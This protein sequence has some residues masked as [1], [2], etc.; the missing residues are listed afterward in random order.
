M[1]KNIELVMNELS[2]TE[3]ERLIILGKEMYP[4]G[5]GIQEGDTD[6]SFLEAGREMLS[7][8]M[9]NINEEIC[10]SEKIRSAFDKTLAEN[11]PNNEENIILP[12]LDIISTVLSGPAVFTAA[13]SIIAKGISKYCSSYWAEA[14]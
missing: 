8:L 12:L 13:A 7:H 11:K 14:R 2:K 9:K 3:D 4:E 10:M 1:D 5:I 6:E